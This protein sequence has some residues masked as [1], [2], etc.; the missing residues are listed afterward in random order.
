[1]C[2]SKAKAKEKQVKWKQETHDNC[3]LMALCFGEEIKL[4]SS[5]FAMK[6]TYTQI[7]VTY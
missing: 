1:M 5:P 2:E 4:I 3:Q 6:Y 7:L